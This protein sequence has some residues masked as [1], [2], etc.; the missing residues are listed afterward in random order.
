MLIFEVNDYSPFIEANISV[1][2][3]IILKRKISTNQE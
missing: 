1:P 3:T 2:E